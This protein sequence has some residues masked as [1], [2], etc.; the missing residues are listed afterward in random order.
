MAHPLSEDELE[1]E[2]DLLFTRPARTVLGKRRFRWLQ[3]KQ[4]IR[5]VVLVGR[6]VT[7]DT[8]T[9]DPLVSVSGRFRTDGGVLGSGAAVTSPANFASLAVGESAWTTTGSVAGNAVATLPSIASAFGEA[10]FEVH[11]ILHVLIA[12]G[13]AASRIPTLSVQT[14]MPTSVATTLTDWTQVGAT[15]TLSQEIHMLV[16]RGPAVVKLN[17][18]GTITDGATSPLPMSLTDAGTLSVTVA[19][20][21]AG[22][23]HALTALVRRVA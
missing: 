21:L 9:L 4:R 12:D 3:F 6:N 20:G 2:S 17:D 1:V 5:P 15:A 22:D 16:P 18:N 7:S 11:Q 10:I 23:S 8:Q 19:A 13:N 14:G